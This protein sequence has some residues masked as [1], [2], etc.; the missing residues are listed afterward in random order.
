MDVGDSGGSDDPCRVIGT[1][2]SIGGSERV[3]EALTDSLPP[4]LADRLVVSEG[5]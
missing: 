2:A 4:S 1:T 5:R 3:T